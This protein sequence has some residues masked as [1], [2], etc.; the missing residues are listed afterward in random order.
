MVLE[1]SKKDIFKEYL[2][3][4]IGCMVLAFSL[5]W[6]LQ[7]NSLAP[8]GVTGF[9][10]VVY[11]ITQIPID[12]TNLAIN[13][14]LFII[15][16]IVLGKRFGLKTAYGTVALSFFI[17]FFYLFGERIFQGNPILVTDDLLLTAIYGGVF[18]GIGLGIVFKSGG[19]TGGTDLAGAILNKYF[20]NLS[21]SKLMMILDL[22][23]VILAGV[24][25]G[26][27]EISMY[28]IIALVIIVKTI[29]FIN[30]G[31][32]Y[33]KAF[34]I[35][36]EDPNKMGKAIMK[37]LNRGVT[38]FNGKGFYSGLNR[39]ILLCV[40]NRSQVAKLKK[41]VSQVDE[42]AFVMVTTTNEVLG[43]GFKN[44]SPK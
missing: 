26:R 15:G 29:D 6:F 5:V 22:M 43:E 17:R 32:S 13:I 7:P 12:I 2:G 10:I 42:K 19:T 37:E 20:E 35:I 33:S 28:S 36:S 39:D 23:V 16:V 38:A 3:I 1:R 14:P 8:G 18:S 40:V 41:V 11:D 24:V 4:G 34:Y 27:V 30:E 9:A 21:T 31:L 44:I 25:K